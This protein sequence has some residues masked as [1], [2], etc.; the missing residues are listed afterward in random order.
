MRA[1]LFAQ[2][3]VALG[4]LSA[5][6]TA[7]A[8]EFKPRI[9]LVFDTSGSMGFDLATAEATGGD[10]S[11][12]YPGNGGISRLSVARSVVSS[13]VESASEVELALM[14]YPQRQGLGINNG[15][16]RG[17]FT[18]YDGLA[19]RPL[20][21]LGECSGDLRAGADPSRPFSLLVP[22][23]SDNEREI[24]SWLDGHES[25][26]VDPELRAEGPTPIAESLRLARVYFE[27]ALTEDAGLRCRKN[28]V[29]VLTDGDE[30]C[31]PPANDVLGTLLDR[32]V[33]LRQMDVAPDVG[34]PVRKDVKVF[35]V[36]FAVTPR[37]VAQLN[38]LA[39]AGG[40][41]V[42]ARGEVDLFNGQ[43]Y[44][45]NDSAGLRR[46]FSRIL[47]EAIPS[48]DCNGLDD[49]CDDRVDEGT[50]N[51]C[52]Q[53]GAAPPEVCN[54]QDDD[55]DGLTDEGARNACGACG[56]LPA[57][58]CN[59]VD[60]D[61]D[62]A[63]DE[64][65]VNACGGCAAVRPDVCNGVDD[66]CDGVVDNVPGTT[67]ALERRCGEDRGQCVAGVEACIGGQFVGC[68][69]TAP[70]LEV[71]DG[72]DND[73]DGTSDEVTRPCGPAEAIG[74]VGACRVGR[75]ACV[76]TACQGAT[77]DCTADGWSTACEG[78]VGP[79]DEVCNGLD[80]D[81][82]EAQDEGLINACGQCGAPRDEACNGRDDN[83]DGR[84][85]EAAT[86]PRGSLCLYGACVQPC[87]ASGECRSDQACIAAWPQG[88]FCHPDA[89]AGARCPDGLVCD[90]AARACVDPCV[91]VTCPDAQVCALGACVTPTCREVGCPAG[92]RCEGGACAAD[93]CAGVTCGNDGFCREGT[94]V[95][96]CRDV[97]C[98]ADRRCVD[99]QCVPDACGGR[100]LRGQLCDAAD[101]ACVQDPCVGVRCPVG[102][103]CV[104]GEC[105]D[106]ASCAHVA[107]PAGL[108]CVDGTCTDNTPSVLPDLNGGP[109]RDASLSDPD[110]TTGF[111]A[112]ARS[113]AAL[114]HD[115]ADRSDAGL[116]TDAALDAVPG[117]GVPPASGCACAVATRAESG[118]L[119]GAAWAFA[120]AVFGLRMRRGRGLAASR[121]RGPRPPTRRAD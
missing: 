31:V 55:C 36:G 7:A 21:Y 112:T 119:G 50:L 13:L 78:A 89:C 2:A 53:C 39:Q 4:L 18:A 76:F 23:R 95:A 118:G 60:D 108:D 22:F 12:E 11:R 44:S 77:A 91:G 35:F 88:R 98:G 45:A 68:T 43:A 24:L 114:D 67:D 1:R 113:D 72:A 42:N 38:A 87:D 20:N 116:D 84:I 10:N 6:A 92:E 40:T 30:S 93:P 56:P 19:Q 9:L 120:L 47:A 100:C 8:T 90:R 73:C 66:D 102:Q 26:P 86:C 71:C 63:I 94:C 41:A 17:A 101:G 96:A 52:G 5:P 117:R 109:E 74:D 14:R 104:G 99:G 48:E 105:R 29:I 79:V 82:D 115:A 111:D 97:A 70:A 25:F 83:C 34:P 121:G 58:A 49:D 69:A 57:E 59:L 15:A 33:A 54:D 51:A 81:C 37:I 62:G 46:A 64:A 85:D 16:L 103:A 75:Q 27:E 28:Y 107:C 80:D 110:A 65:V 32:T 3:L 61:C 106:D